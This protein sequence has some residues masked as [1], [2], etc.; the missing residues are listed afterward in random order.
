MADAANPASTASQ[1]SHPLLREGGRG[2]GQLLRGPATTDDGIAIV[3]GG[4]AGM[5]LALALHRHGVA[6][7][8]FDA[9]PRGAAREDQRILALSHGSRQILEWLG[10]WQNIVATPIAT[11]HVSQRGGFGRTRL[12]AQE[13]GVPALGYVAAAA[14]VSAALDD[15]LAAARILLHDNCRISHADLC[16]GGIR[17]H[18]RS[19]IMPTQASL[20]VYAE[21]AIENDD[22][23]ATV[24]RDYGQQAVICTAALAPATPHR[25]LAYERFTPQGPLAL[26]PFGKQLAVVYT[27]LD[28]DAAV[29]AALSDAEF[30]ERLQAHFGSRLEF[31]AVSPRHVYPL[32]LRYRKSP[33]GPRA[34]WLGNAAQTLHPVAGQGFNLA[35]RDTWELA[36][37]LA[38]ANDPGAPAVLERYARARRLDRRGT[39]S[40]TDALIRVF[41]SNDPLLRH[42]RG[43]A[44][45]A[46]DLLPPAR[47]FV[48][49]RML[50]GARAW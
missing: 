19:G 8:V 18:T 44:L 10:V 21:G 4:P 26:L 46:L 33:V 15:A 25:N 36:R 11:I 45:L 43:L 22:D 3:G 47:S 2:E 48:A 41:G 16:A 24:T 31:A 23:A 49:R 7:Q 37:S 29:L 39:I 42:A 14:S 6:A 12:S 30:L 32:A 28:E 40:F 17:L 5:A 9:R 34:V 27:C 1:N 20:V 50:F 38:H 35:L 13:Q